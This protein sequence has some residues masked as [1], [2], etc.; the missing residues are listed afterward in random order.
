M[1]HKFA[2]GGIISGSIPEFLPET[3]E[4]VIPLKTTSKNDARLEVAYDILSKVH[5]DLC[6]SRKL[7]QAEE[8][9]D[10]MRRLILLSKKI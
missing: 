10:I 8:L 4:T 2:K 6:N 3:H 5:S 9:I 7:E 1:A